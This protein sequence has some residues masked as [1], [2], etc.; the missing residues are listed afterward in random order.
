M[1]FKNIRRDQLTWTCDLCFTLNRYWRKHC[2]NCKLVRRGGIKEF[3]RRK[4]RKMN[5]RPRKV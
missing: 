5:G 1:G 2:R 4:H 3:D